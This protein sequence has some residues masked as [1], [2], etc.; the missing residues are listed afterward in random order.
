MGLILHHQLCCWPRSGIL[1]SSLSASRLLLGWKGGVTWLHELGEGFWGFLPVFTLIPYLSPQTTQYLTFYT[2][3]AICGLT[4]FLRI[5]S[6][7]FACR[8]LHLASFTL[9]SQSPLIHPL[10]ILQMFYFLC[11]LLSFLHFSLFYRFIP[12][13]FLCC[14]FCGFG[15]DNQDKHACA[16]WCIDSC[17]IAFLK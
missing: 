3:P 8:Q 5:D 6:T 1:T 2:F 12:I 10:S 15:G 4:G 11:L 13:L 7:R 9:L 16:I 14:D 17:E